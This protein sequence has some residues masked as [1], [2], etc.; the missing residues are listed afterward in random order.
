MK[1]VTWQGKQ[2][3]EIRNV[4]DPKI[5]EPTDAIIRITATAI[6][7][8]DLHLYHHGEA[9]LE[10]GY[11]V[12][13]EPMG[14]VEEVGSAVTKL[15][16]GQRVVIPFNISCGHCHFCLNEM[17][18]QCDRSNSDQLYGGLF[19]FGS[20]NGNHWGG[21]AEYLRVPFADTT[22]FIVPDND[23]ADEKVLFLSDI[24]PTAYW[25]VQNAGVKQGDTVIVLGSGPVGLFAQ[26]F[27][28]MAGASR[29]IAVDPV[30]HRIDKAG[31]YNNVETFLLEDVQNAGTDLYELTKGGADVIIDCVGMDGLEPVKEKA[32]NLVSL[33]S[34]TISPIQI[35]A[36]AAKKFGTVQITGVYMTPASS[37]PLQEFFMRDITVKHG[38]A[39]VVHLM[40]K[41]YEMIA[42]NQFDPAQIITHAM[43]LA[44]AARAYE[45]FD[46]KEDKNIKVVLK[47]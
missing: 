8:S 32:K 19:G 7:G 26:K 10:K 5:L 14:F 12:G 45:I 6:C 43:P 29:V 25:S 28:T 39:P 36:K 1:A 23:L 37:Y 42:D 47:P 38:Q 44:D 31:R 18:S 30:Q 16:K 41:I 24:L 20:L 40:P 9:V 11:V 34:G 2:K 22:S 33:Q 17:E 35:A 21:Q 3:M 4:E 13:H 27:A 46:K 15:K